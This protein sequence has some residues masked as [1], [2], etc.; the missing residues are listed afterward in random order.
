MQNRETT[1]S[2]GG[3]RYSALRADEAATAFA[4]KAT[5][6]DMDRQVEAPE[7]RGVTERILG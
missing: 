2:R 4:E 3:V 1:S 6:P 5:F 7:R